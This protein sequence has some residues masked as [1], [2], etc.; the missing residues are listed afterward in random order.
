MRYI[1]P[2]ILVRRLKARS[3]A[4]LFEYALILFL[5]SIAAILILQGIGGSTNTMVSSIN[6]G[7][8]P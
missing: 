5:V 2:A 3:G 4:T 7:F 6:N 8:A 1:N